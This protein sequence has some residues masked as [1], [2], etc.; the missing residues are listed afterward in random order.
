L[1]VVGV[2]NI[3]YAMQHGVVSV[4]EVNPRASR[5][6]PFVSKSTGVPLAKIAAKLKVGKTLKG[7]GIQGYSWAKHVSIKESVFPFTKFPQAR[8]FLGPE[9]RSTGE[10][11]GISD[12][13]GT[14]FAK[15]SLAAGTMLP[16]AGTVFVSLNDNDKQARAVNVV[17]SYVRLGF[18]VIA[19]EGTSAFLTAQ[20]IRNRPVLKASEGTLNIIDVIRNGWVQL[21]INTPLGQ[22]SRKDE[23]AIG[24]TAYE[25]KVPFL[26]TLSAAAAAAKSIEQIKNQTFT[27]MSMQEY[28]E[29]ARQGGGTRT[30]ETLEDCTRLVEYIRSFQV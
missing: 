5:T 8:H 10:V 30:L 13:F 7:L 24:R 23:H 21:I 20:G 11:M 29:L 26:T 14:S 16:T 17:R 3:Q 18:K 12:N 6:T 22:V 1:H 28:H 25:Y 19:T 2:V 9:M 4:L 15:A 27:V